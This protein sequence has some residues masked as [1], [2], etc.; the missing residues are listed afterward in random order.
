MTRHWSSTSQMKRILNHSF[1]DASAK[2]RQRRFIPTQQYSREIKQKVEEANRTWCLVSG[3]SKLDDEISTHEGHDDVFHE[4]ATALERPRRQRIRTVSFSE[5][6]T[7]HTYAD[8][9][10][11]TAEESEHST[12]VEWCK[13]AAPLG[14][15]YLCHR[16]E[17]C[18][19]HNFRPCRPVKALYSWW[20]DFKCDKRL[21]FHPGDQST[22]LFFKIQR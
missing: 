1:P 3:Q 22:G 6:V 13:T 21:E 17:V 11:S 14:C 5:D 18:S 15:C 19:G 12:V 16:T 8:K 2:K 7:V 9:M 4:D 10:E 20:H